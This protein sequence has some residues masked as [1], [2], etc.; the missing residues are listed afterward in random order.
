[1]RQL[2]S[3]ILQRPALTYSAGNILN[4]VV[5]LLL[6]P[7]MLKIDQSAGVVLAKGLLAAQ[8]TA[9]LAVYSFPV[10]TPRT[11]VHEKS[12]SV[13]RLLLAIL[14][15]QLLMLLLGGLCLLAIVRNDL[16]NLHYAICGLL[17]GYAAVL[18]WQWYHISRPSL[19]IQVLLLLSTRS[20]L[21][22]LEGLAMVGELPAHPEPVVVSLLLAIL[23]LLPTWPTWQ[24]AIRNR[25]GAGMS[26]SKLH[27]WQLLIKEF[28]HG[29]NLFIASLLSAIYT[30][31]PATLVA[32]L[33]PS[34]LVAI[35]QFDRLRT[36]LSNL[37]GMLLNLI[38][39]L[40]LQHTP[41]VLA[42]RFD[43][44][45]RWLILPALLAA[46]TLLLC[47]LWLPV[48]Q[49]G[50]MEALHINTTTLAIALACA[51]SAS[52]SNVIALTF[53]HPLDNDRPYR[54]VI[55]TGALVFVV[56]GAV[57]HSAGLAHLTW[58][59]MLAA[60]LAEW[61]ILTGLWLVAR[62]VRA[63]IVVA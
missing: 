60:G 62:R 10:I 34:G 28:G 5:M 55:L 18:Q 46:S 21:L 58:P 29:R 38:Y 35:Q 32:S 15:Y 2:T 61:L 6:L 57:V 44:T 41:Q 42:Q 19:L 59:I 4:T 9:V 37:T 8:L 33:N 51:A 56:G 53:L 20:L 43:R 48:D 30:L 14:K 36:S 49:L 47:S 27:G 3:L 11:L 23:M 39:P 25:R 45:Q 13:R 24:E 26:P 16:N 40:L 12:A 52:A 50:W 1:M 7:A 54:S 17:I 22:L 63:H 31:G